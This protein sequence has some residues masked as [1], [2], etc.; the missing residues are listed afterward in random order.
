MAQAET[1]IWRKIALTF[2]PLGFRLFRNQRY[3]G[4]IVRGDVVTS[5][6]ADCGVGGDG[7]SDL[8][9]WR[10]ILITP[11][12]VGR[13]IAQFV[14]IETKTVTGRASDMQ[15]AFI[16]AVRKDGGLAGICRNDDDVHKL[17][18]EYDD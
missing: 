8:I 13:R 10:S 5:G 1:N 4:K 7:G 9:G 16:N 17:I 6:Y 2:S 14:A 15:Q 11:A 12:M 3:K 18:G